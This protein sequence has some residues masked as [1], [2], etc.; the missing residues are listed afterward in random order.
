MRAVVV[1][2]LHGIKQLTDVLRLNLRV[3]LQRRLKVRVTQLPASQF[4]VVRVT[5]HNR[6]VEVTQLVR[7]QATT[8]QPLEQ[9][10]RQNIREV[11]E[12][13]VTTQISAMRPTT[14]TTQRD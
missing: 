11:S 10:V 14:A 8:L 4:R 9:R 3:D 7:S 12:P 6:L 1:N 2:G 5:D 13:W